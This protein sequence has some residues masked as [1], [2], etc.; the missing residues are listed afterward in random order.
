[1]KHSCGAILYSFEP[2]THDIGIILGLEHRYWLPF[3][4]CTEFG[5]DYESAA[6]R[7]IYEETC[8]LV[9]VNSIQLEHNFY[10]SKK[11]YHIG[12]TY[13]DYNI[14]NDFDKERKKHKNNKA[15]IEKTKLK[16]FT[17]KNLK[18]HMSKIHKLTKS[19]IIYYWDKLM[20]L[21][22]SKQTSLQGSRGRSHIINFNDCEIPDEDDVD[23]IIDAV[24]KKKKQ[25][26]IIKK[27]RKEFRK[28]LNTMKKDINK[29]KKLSDMINCII[30]SKKQ[31]IDLLD[32]GKHV[33]KKVKC[34][35]AIGQRKI[36]K[37][38]TFNVN[39]IVNGS[40]SLNWR[41]LE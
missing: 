15:F 5:E 3:K 38:Y 6:I 34:N 30:T 39:Q 35:T 28:I 1:M 4:G 33:D 29:S 23:K 21:N 2:E 11:H 14:V 36:S 16:F 17:L 7:E 41:R 32:I 40:E 22:C 19:S 10:T 18:K 24:K 25:Q 26:K 9:D 20:M 27:K 12:L 37:R 31:Q 8:G 13:A